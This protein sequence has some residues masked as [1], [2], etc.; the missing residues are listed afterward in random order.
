MMFCSCKRVAD[1]TK[2]DSNNDKRFAV[3]ISYH[4]SQRR[5]VAAVARALAESFGKENLFFDVFHPSAFE[6]ADAASKLREIYTKQSDLVVPFFCNKYGSHGW[7]GIEWDDIRKFSD[8]A[9]VLPV[10]LYGGS[11]PSGWTAGGVPIRVRSKNETGRS[12]ANRIVDNYRQRFPEGYLTLDQWR[13][14]AERPRD[15]GVEFGIIIVADIWDFSVTPPSRME[16]VIDTMWTIAAELGLATGNSCVAGLLDGLIIAMRRGRYLDILEKCELWISRFGDR[17]SIEKGSPPVQLRV[18][19]HRGD[20]YQLTSRNL[21][22]GAG[23]NECSRLVRMGGPGQI[24]LSEDFVEGWKKDISWSRESRDLNVLCPLPVEDPFDLEIKAGQRTL[25]RFY[26]TPLDAPI[27]FP[28]L[29]QAHKARQVL[30]KVLDEIEDEFVDI[31]CDKRSDLTSKKINTRVSVFVFDRKNPEAKQLVPTE[32]RFLRHPV[33]TGSRQAAIFKG[34]TAY[35]I[36]SKCGPQG[37]IARAFVDKKPYV[38]TRLRPYKGKKYQAEYL[39][40]LTEPPWNLDADRVVGFGRHARSFISVPCWLNKES[41]YADAVLCID[42]MDALEG[43]G[44][45]LLMECAE[46]FGRY[47]GTLIAALLSLRS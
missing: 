24:V 23:P 7:T 41:H 47:F 46:N 9:S 20:F 30:M 13:P 34:N 28:Q 4:C 26:K 10:L 21:V 29:Q 1:L 31:V 33:K 8:K 40:R 12:I 5:K 3:A 18:A 45:E 15:A 37:G 11:E 36:D 14:Q 25:F 39:Q 32:F 27:F 2:A 19:V 38:I 22:V 43:V 6:G 42:T 17:T 16:Y 35:P 44:E